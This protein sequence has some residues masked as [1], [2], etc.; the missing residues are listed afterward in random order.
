MAGKISTHRVTSLLRLNST[1]HIKI[2]DLREVLYVKQK[3]KKRFIF[4]RKLGPSQVVYPLNLRE[5]KL[6]LLKKLKRK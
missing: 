1:D 2:Q 3:L 6:K 4:Y 5:S